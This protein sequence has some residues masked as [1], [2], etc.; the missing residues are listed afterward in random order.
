[1]DPQTKLF[2]KL[3]ANNKPFAVIVNIPEYNIGNSTRTYDYFI[4]MCL[5]DV[6]NLDITYCLSTQSQLLCEIT[7]KKAH[8]EDFYGFVDQKFIQ[9]SPN[10][11]YGRI[12]ELIDTSFMDYY[13]TFNT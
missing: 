3:F 9:F 5:C 2:K 4:L 13:R 8:I 6:V 1:M 11:K 7:L 12:Y 10:N